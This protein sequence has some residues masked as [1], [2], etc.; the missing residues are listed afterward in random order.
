MR[1]VHRRTIPPPTPVRHRVQNEIDGFLRFAVNLGS[2][3]QQVQHGH[4]RRMQMS[5]EAVAF[6]PSSLPIPPASYQP[7]YEPGYELRHELGEEL[8]YE[9]SREPGNEQRSAKG[10]DYVA[11]P[12]A[13]AALFVWEE[14]EDD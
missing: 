9:L 6:Q 13:M 8:G 14:D 4:R 3:P 12:L 10:A 11:A 5:A 2:R 1:Q 7:G